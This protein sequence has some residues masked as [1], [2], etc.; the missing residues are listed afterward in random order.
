MPYRNSSTMSIPQSQVAVFCLAL[1]ILGITSSSPAQSSLVNQELNESFKNFTLLDTNSIGNLQNPTNFQVDTGQKQ[2]E[3]ILQ[4]H[5]LRTAKYRTIDTNQFGDHSN[6]S[7]TIRTFKGR[8]AGEP[9]SNVRLSINEGAV[10]GYFFSALG[11]FFIEPARRYSKAAS[12]FQS[13]V[14]QEK[15]LKKEIAISCGTELQQKIRKGQKFMA[16]QVESVRSVRV[17]EVATEADYE[18]VT[19][20]GSAAQANN[21][22]L[23][24]LNMVEGTYDQELGLNIDVVFQHTWSAPD[25][26]GAANADSVLRSFKDYWNA[27]FPVAQYPRDIAHIWTAKPNALAQGYAFIGVVCSNPT[28]SYGLSGKIEWAP[29]KYDITAHEIAHNLSANHADSAQGCSDTVMNPVL[30][31]FTP[32][33]FCTFSRSEVASYVN[34]NSSCLARRVIGATRSDFDGDGKTDIS[35]F[36]PTNGEWWIQKSN[37]GVLSAQFGQLTDKVVAADYSGDGKADIAFFR[38]SIGQWFVLR[39][40]DSSF[41]AF[42]FGTSTDIPAPADYDGDGKSDAAVFRPSTAT[43]FILRSSDGGVVATPFGAGGD[44]LIPAD[45]DGD[46]KADLAVFRTNG[47]NKEWWVLKSTGGSFASSFGT[48]GD[49]A[50]PGD[51]T[52]DGKADIALYRPTSGMWFVLRSEDSSFYAFSFG[53]AGDRPAPGDYDGD[54]KFDATVFRPTGA[55]WYTLRSSDSNVAATSFGIATDEPVVG[56]Y[57]P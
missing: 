16:T 42:P 5:D 18:F 2:F 3:L 25:P 48:T 49:K 28:F 36:R 27:N 8:I 32:L 52:G 40:E 29:A 46:G 22:I 20:L 44:A 15:D 55:A 1:F 7:P 34:V 4:S 31:V 13:V 11:K 12:A 19:A 54:G 24:V 57:V 6:D 30:S 14:Y 9:T 33:T 37:S 43:W 23:S 21:E 17:I 41:Y 50:V 35:I 38:A 51:Y 53:Q 45:Y 47:A 10:E 39:S 26:F 56:Y